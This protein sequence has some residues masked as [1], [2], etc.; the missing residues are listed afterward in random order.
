M[1]ELDTF[2]NGDG[3]GDGPALNS[4]EPATA[5]SEST[6]GPA[7]VGAVI[8]DDGA[9]QGVPVEFPE[10]KEQDEESALP[11]SS[12]NL[13]EMDVHP[14][15]AVK[16]REGMDPDIAKAL[17]NRR[18][19]LY[20]NEIQGPV[21]DGKLSKSVLF[22]Y[23]APSFSTVPLTLLISI[24]V[25][26]FY[27]KL[28]ADLA[29]LAFFQALARGFDVIT[30]PSMSYVTDSWRGKHGRR[31]PFLAIGCIPY[32]LSLFFLMTPF[33]SL[34][35]TQVSTW[36]GIFYIL[37]FL[38]NTFT[39]IPYDS[40]GPELT[41]NPSD[42]SVLFFVCT[43]FDGVGAICATLLPVVGQLFFAMGRPVVTDSCDVPVDGVIS[44]ASCGSRLAEKVGLGSTLTDDQAC[45]IWRMNESAASLGYT[46]ELCDS[47]FDPA[48]KGFVGNASDFC[49]CLADCKIVN[50]LDNARGAYSVVGLFFGLWYIITMLIAVKKVKERSQL[51]GRPLPPPPPMLPAML[52]TFQNKTFSLLLPAWICDALV[53]SLIASLL[54]YYVRYVIEPEF[55][56]ERCQGGLATGPDVPIFCSSEAV[57]GACV[58]AVLFAAFLGTPMWLLLVKKI[59]KRNTWLLWSLTMA[60]TNVSFFFLGSGD[61]VGVIVCA[62]LNGIPMGAKFLADAILADV[63]DY[64]EF[65]T[66]A[67]SEA[68]YTMFKSFLPKIAAIPASAVPIALL[69]VFGHIPPQE[70]VVQKQ[71]S[72]CIRPY[73][74]ITMIAIPTSLS[75]LAFFLKLRFPLKSV[76]QNEK[77]SEGIGQHLLGKPAKCPVSGVSYSLLPLSEA[78]MKDAYRLDNFMGSKVC[79]RALK[80]PE[81]ES[82]RFL[83]VSF[84]QLS[85]AIAA[86]VGSAAWV[87]G[88][89]SLLK[90]GDD[91]I[92]VCDLSGQS[93]ANSSIMAFSDPDASCGVRIEG[94]EV[95]LS[96]I[97]VLG[98]VFFGVS[99]TGVFITCLRA[100]GARSLAKNMPGKELL[101]KIREQRVLKEKCREFDTSIMQACKSYIEPFRRASAVSTHENKEE[102]QPAAI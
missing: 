95:N 72:S 62:G 60:I 44:L 67:R 59:G 78:E 17:R 102:P 40:L 52:N 69:G 99:V 70:G 43:L 12:V 21:H 89:F 37:F 84:T 49:Q 30:D 38:W 92:A 73:I 93:S 56:D 31:R 65:L 82:K 87:G 79:D 11:R 91:N 71:L 13:E 15:D 96:F 80:D 16:L 94:L 8:Q 6:A 29:M 51:S 83:K 32:G 86:M 81:K 68:T 101:E 42:R 24:Y 28:G 98:V 3:D 14:D 27:E 63:I 97:P 47:L 20:A 48:Q 36:F 1:A 7:D 41:D 88:T 57:L 53:N 90:S 55:A 74:I 25:V 18:K 35:A 22:A 46:A 54:T 4:A 10:S 66:G 39:N 100:A 23:S 9:P 58:A 2:S 5:T 61:I 50:R 77:I 64:D 75:L 33:P 19:T 45:R 85:L 34:D 76:K 26:Q